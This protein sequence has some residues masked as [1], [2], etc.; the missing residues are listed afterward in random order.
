MRNR[1]S[2]DSI[3]SGTAQ[4][5]VLSYR[6]PAAPHPEPGPEG[7]SR[8][9]HGG[10]TPDLWLGGLAA[11]IGGGVWIYD[12]HWQPGV[13]VGLMSWSAL[14]FIYPLPAWLFDWPQVR[15]VDAVSNGIDLLDMIVGVLSIFS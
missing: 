2:F 10:S 7:L 15:W 5:E 3:S 9:T 8:R 12:R 4:D 1:A 6:I 11:V 14:A 13:L